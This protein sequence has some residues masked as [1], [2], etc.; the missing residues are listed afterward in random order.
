MAADAPF[1]TSIMLR[2][3]SWVGIDTVAIGYEEPTVGV[4][5]TVAVAFPVSTSMVP[6][7]ASHVLPSVA[8][9]SDPVVLDLSAKLS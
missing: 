7:T 5:D 6:E 3:L 2:I 9:P 4:A 8:V 1:P